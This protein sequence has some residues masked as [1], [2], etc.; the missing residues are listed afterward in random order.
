MLWLDA[1]ALPQEDFEELI[2]TISAYEGDVKTKILHGGKRYEFAVRLSRALTA[3][4]RT[5]LP[6]SCVKLV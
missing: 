3:E 5:F 4:L 2:E 1:R 6:E